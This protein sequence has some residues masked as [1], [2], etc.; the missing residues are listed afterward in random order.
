MH[1]G[2]IGASGRLGTLVCE[3]LVQQKLTFTKIARE[4]LQN[5]PSFMQLLQH[6]SESMIILDISLPVGT[7]NICNIINNLEEKNLKQIKGLV[8]GTTGHNDRQK[9]LLLSTSQKIPICMVSN[10]SKGVYLFEEILKAK[11]SQG[12]TVTELARALGFDMAMTEI[13]HTLKKDAP[14]GTAIT[15]AEAGKIP[16]KQI[17]SVRVGKVVGDHSIHLSADSESL[18]IKHTAHARKLFAEG[19]IELCK[20][21]Y[22]Q[23]PK[24]G[25]LRK[26][27]FFIS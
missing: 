21:I 23:A 9:Q 26:E 14:S 8:I 13:H 1:I 22:T 7:E 6:V 17:S 5:I 16:A 20:N 15:L 4:D 19:A 18:E 10:F 3:N 11:T 12:L 24:P 27:D 2:L 25:F